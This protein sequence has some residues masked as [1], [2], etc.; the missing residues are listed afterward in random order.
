[1]HNDKHLP[2]HRDDTTAV[3]FLACAHAYTCWTH[4]C[5]RLGLISFPLFLCGCM[6]ARVCVCVFF[7]PLISNELA[8]TTNRCAEGCVKVSRCIPMH[9]R[10]IMHS[11]EALD[12]SEIG[13]MSGIRTDSAER[14]ILQV[15]ETKHLESTTG[16]FCCASFLNTLKE[17]WANKQRKIRSCRFQ[18][19]RSPPLH[20]D[21]F[22]SW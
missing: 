2:G 13:F 20:C 18:V 5:T 6:R 1:M 8:S 21:W 16:S 4:A 9:Y 3:I 19:K 15:M 17:L 11:C 12:S 7:I 14:L 22:S 10:R